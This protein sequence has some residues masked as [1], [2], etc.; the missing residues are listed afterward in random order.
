MQ[1]GDPGGHEKIAG[2]LREESVQKILLGWIKS[3]VNTQ[4]R[5][6]SSS[7]VFKAARVQPR[8]RVDSDASRSAGIGGQEDLEADGLH[9]GLELLL[10]HHVGLDLL[11][12][13]HVGLDMQDGALRLAGQV[14]HLTLGVQSDVFE[15]D[16][17]LVVCKSKI[18]TRCMWLPKSLSKHICKETSLPSTVSNLFVK[19]IFY[20]P[21]THIHTYHFD[22]YCNTRF[23]QEKLL[24]SGGYELVPL[25]ADAEHSGAPCV[26]SRREHDRVT[27]EMVAMA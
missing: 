10:L 1:S 18:R 7:E 5:N 20:P 27:V 15:V 3:Y 21:N 2:E 8:A 4:P 19:T 13:L 14:E 24:T 12:L 16:V 6:I 22:V 11:L 17:G 23:P 9:V 25:F 26:Q